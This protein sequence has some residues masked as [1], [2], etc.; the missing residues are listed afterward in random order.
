MNHRQ[1]SLCRCGNQKVL[2]TRQLTQSIET[3]G[4]LS[5]CTAN[6][7]RGILHPPP[8]V[9]KPAKWLD[10]PTN[11]R[12]VERFFGLESRRTPCPCDEPLAFRGKAICLVLQVLNQRN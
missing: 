2:R 11:D 8:L 5:E 1:E 7:D 9:P 6:K 12:F 3:A 4:D 10:E